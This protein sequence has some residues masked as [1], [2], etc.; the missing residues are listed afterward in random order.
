MTFGAMRRWVR[1][2]SR[3]RWHHRITGALELEVR[4]AVAHDQL[5]VKR[6]ATQLVIEWFARDVHP[7]DRDLAPEQQARRFVERA[8]IDT[9]AAI[10]QLFDGVPEIDCL[11][12]RVWDRTPP[13]EPVLAGTVSRAE[14]EE[15]QEHR[16]PIMTLKSLGLVFER[17]RDSLTDG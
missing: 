13:C 15:C 1:A 9:V 17:S 14:F 4:G 7:W 12:V 10:Q 5:R 11:H 2:R 16:S 6:C 3:L 8:V